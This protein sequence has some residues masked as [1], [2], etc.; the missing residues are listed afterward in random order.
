MLKFCVI[1]LSSFFFVTCTY[2]QAI[3]SEE[4]EQKIHFQGPQEQ[5][6]K[7]S[8]KVDEGKN[9]KRIVFEGPEEKVVRVEQSQS[10]PYDN[11]PKFEG[12][13]ERVIRISPRKKKSNKK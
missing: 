13:E 6:I 12:P 8:E 10:K 9:E 7:L 5:T 1:V 4:N 11:R 3:V 2:G